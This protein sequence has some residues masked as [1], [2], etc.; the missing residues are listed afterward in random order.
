MNAFA[1]L[2]LAFAVNAGSQDTLVIRA[3]SPVW[4][5]V[6][7][8][9]EVRI[10]VLEGQDAYTFGR[11]RTIAA[12]KDGS[13]FVGD[14]HGPRLL[15]YDSMG[16][17]VKQIGRAGAGPGE[18]R[19]VRDLVTIPDGR[20]VH[21][22]HETSRVTFYSPKGEHQSS[23]PFRSSFFGLFRSDSAGR[24]MILGSRT[25]RG[26]PEA[27]DEKPVEG[28]RLEPVVVRVSTSGTV[29][30]TIQ[31]PELP[32][33]PQV[34]SFGVMAGEGFL[35]PFDAENTTALS[36]HGYHVTGYTPRYAIDLHRG[37]QVLRIV[38]DIRPVPVARAERAEWQAR[39]D[40]YSK[41]EPR[42]A[43]AGVR[44]PAIKPAFRQIDVD[45]DGR[46]WVYR[47]VAAQK[48][49]IAARPSNSALPPITWREP[50]TFDVFQPDGRFLGTVVLPSRTQLFLMRGNLLWGITRGELFEETYI[51][52]YR[53]E[54]R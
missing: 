45:E 39:A 51:V 2:L 47:Y 34:S 9:Q 53:L 31:Q 17:F 21:Y 29:H 15:M 13:I 48:Q 11:V 5:S 4:K 24:L 30:D 10:G 54:T 33:R 44:V 1:G 35:Q 43:S 18:Y 22:D 49:A 25:A 12:G 36:P 50:P 41:R 3:T 52:R 23:F 42:G 28:P 6:R 26:A 37:K 38:R 46:I 7:L 27:G 32:R 14:E 8:V 20:L 40:Y 19:T 16:R